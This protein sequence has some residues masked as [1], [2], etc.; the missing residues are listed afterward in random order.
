MIFGWH[1]TTKDIVYIWICKLCIF[2]L[3]TLEI[4]CPS[5]KV[6]QAHAKTPYSKSLLSSI[7]TA[8]GCSNY[9]LI[10]L[11]HHFLNLLSN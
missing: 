8:H 4:P 9:W 7:H 5:I 1:V 10:I 2:I 6:I 3:N 11:Q